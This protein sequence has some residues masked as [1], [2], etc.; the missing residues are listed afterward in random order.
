MLDFWPAP[1]RP[2]VFVEA[3]AIVTIVLK[4]GSANSQPM[5]KWCLL[6]VLSLSFSLV[7]AQDS[8]PKSTSNT[9]LG[10]KGKTSDNTKK[11]QK[12]R[13]LL[14]KDTQKTMYGNRCVVEITRA[15]GFEYMVTLKGQPGYESEVQRAFHNFGV[16]VA[17]MVR[18]G[19]FWKTSLRKKIE[20]CRQKSGDYV[21]P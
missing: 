3:L 9:G 8:A 13:Y 19:P 1:L 4:L 18:N 15:K 6:L 20:A 12:I 7:H 16:N 10:K 11:P 21:G 17:L 14:K 2:V 5:S